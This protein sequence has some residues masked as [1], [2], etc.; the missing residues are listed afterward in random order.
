M[1]SSRSPQADRSLRLPAAAEPVRVVLLRSGGALL[2]AIGLAW[3]SLTRNG[4]VPFLSGVDLAIHEF[5]HLLFLWAPFLVMALAGSVL[6]V[7]VPAALAGY[8]GW[9]GDRFALVCM[10]AW[11]GVSLHNVSV[12]VRDATRMELPLFGDDGSGSGH[13]WRNVLGRLDLLARTDDIADL[14]RALAV[15][16]FAAAVVLALWWAWQGLGRPLAP[17]ARSLRG[18]PVRE[19]AVRPDGPAPARPIA[20]PPRPPRPGRSLR[21][22]SR[23]RRHGPDGRSS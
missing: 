1:L 21:G 15:L 7:A 16:A 9:R 18:L 23:R 10:L 6:Q 13:D 2:V 14:V 22:P 8:F 11:L 20:L 19:V 3:L 12:Y 17:R 4:W 5:G